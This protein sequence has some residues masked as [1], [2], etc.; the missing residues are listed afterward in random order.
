MVDW[1]LLY[2]RSSE[3]RALLLVESI[4]TGLYTLSEEQ[5]QVVDTKGPGGQ[6]IIVL[7]LGD[8]IEDVPED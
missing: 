1:E 4:A 2:H 3:W 8:V 7:E 6:D 5:S